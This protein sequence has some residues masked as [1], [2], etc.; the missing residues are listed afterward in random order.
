MSKN[1]TSI[2]TNAPI[3][4]FDSGLGGISIWRELRNELPQEKLVYLADSK[5]APY[6]E[7]SQEEIIQFSIKN[8]EL[9]IQKGCKIIVIACNTATTNA[10]GVLRKKFEIPFVGIEPATKPAALTSKTGKIGILATQGTLKSDLFIATSNPFREKLEIIEAEG[11]G[12]VKLIEAGK[13]QETIPLLKEYL[14][15]MLTKGIDHLVLGC[16]H[17]PFLTP[18]LKQLLPNTIKVIDS[19][20]AVA[21]QTRKV[22]DQHQLLNYNDL[23]SL[24]H[25]IFTN[26]DIDILNSFLDHLAL[27]N[28]E[29]LALDF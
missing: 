1:T 10:I 25:P 16:T 27:T 13:I 23:K 22:L 26:G 7:K 21:L 14:A 28:Y 12:L 18:L 3:G 29:S 9:L 15:P 17:Y 5:N 19:G 6:G 8:T 20:R 11:K 24:K 4:I 2:P